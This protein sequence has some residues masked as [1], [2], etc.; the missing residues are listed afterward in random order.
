MRKFVSAARKAIVVVVGA[1]A[2]GATLGALPA[3]AATDDWAPGSVEGP[4]YRTATSSI[5]GSKLSMGIW[6]NGTD[7]SVNGSITD[8]AGDGRS[9][10]S[11][12][13]YEV[14]YDGAWHNHSRYFGK[15]SGNGVRD[16]L[17]SQRGRYPIRKLYARACVSDNGT[18]TTCDPSWR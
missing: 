4:G 14:Y 17:L 6:W 16:V 10:V 13:T 5:Y 7:V 8:T 12:I 1:A 15:A 11:E 2:L 3:E 9:A 18:V